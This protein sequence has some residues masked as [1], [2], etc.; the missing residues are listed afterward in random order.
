MPPI[1]KLAEVPQRPPRDPIALPE[2]YRALIRR[3]PLFRP[4][5]S[6]SIGRSTD[7]PATTAVAHSEVSDQPLVNRWPSTP[8][9]PLLA[10][11]LATFLVGVVFGG[12]V[13]GVLTA[14]RLDR[15]GNETLLLAQVQ[16]LVRSAEGAKAQRADTQDQLARLDAAI[17]RLR[18]QLSGVT[19][20]SPAVAPTR[21]HG[22]PE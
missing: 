16:E 3:D 7:A 14:S 6:A 17:S 22:R 9:R 15:S 11:L 4:K 8:S 10:Q 12:A 1:R 19:S 13:V 2:R 21:G 20:N 18:E 5:T